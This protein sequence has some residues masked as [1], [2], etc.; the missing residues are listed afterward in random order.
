[1]TRSAARR[2]DLPLAESQRVLLRASLLPGEAAREA[3]RA[4]QRDPGLDDVGEGEYQL[5]PQT[6]ANLMADGLDAS[7]IPDLARLKGISKRSWFLASLVRRSVTEVLDHL[8]DAAVPTI[9]FG[10]LD[11]MEAGIC[12]P[13]ARHVDVGSVLIT[14][15]DLDRADEALRD[16][17]WTSHAPL[18]SGR[19]RRIASYAIYEREGGR[20]VRV[21]WRAFRDDDA[22]EIEDTMWRTSEPLPLGDARCRRLSAD[23]LVLQACGILSSGMFGLPRLVC[24]LK[25]VVDWGGADIDWAFVSDAARR[26]RM[27]TPLAAVLRFVAEELGAAVPPELCSVV[28]TVDEALPYHAGRSVRA[29]VSGLW[30]RY[31]AVQRDDGRRSSVVG[32]GRLTVEYCQYIWGLRSPWQV[33]V[34]API[35][36]YR[37]LQHPENE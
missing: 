32:F 31:A 4:W 3:W 19:L 18:P 15:S 23:L 22:V 12:A 2:P 35:R 20:S 8:E 36:W 37:S 27:L 13:R 28:G 10:G 29:D 11:L 16:A 5:L 30:E 6:C 34:V 1:M 24:D 25:C 33:P 7:A 17:G 26:L 14:S 9:V 21:W